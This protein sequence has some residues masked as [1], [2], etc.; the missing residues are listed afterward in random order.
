MSEPH[1][2]HPPTR[3]RVLPTVG[4]LARLGRW[5]FDHRL[6]A[7]GLWIVA[8]VGVFGAVGT[9]GPAYEDAFDVPNS[10][11]AEGFAVLEEH[12]AHLGAGGRSGTI[13][14]SAEQGVDDPHVMAAMQE[15]F[16]L[17]DSGFPDDAGVARHPGATVVSP[18]SAEGAGQIARDGPLSDQL[19]YAQVN[20]A[21]DIGLTEASQIGAAIADHAPV[22]DGLEVLPGGTALGEFAVPETE[23]IGLAFAV[24]ILIL[25]FGSVLAMG[26]PLAVAVA[27]VGAGVGLTALLS[28]LLTVPDY[29]TTVAIMIGLGVGIDYAL[30]I[31]VRYR[32]GLHEGLSPRAATTRAMDTAGRSVV[33]AGLTVVLSLLGILLIGLA[34]LSGLAI[35]ASVTVLVTMISAITLLP[36]LLGVAGPR[37]EV[38]R[39]RGV[40]MAAFVALALLGVGIGVPAL[41]AGGGVLA[42]VA[43]LTSFVLPA[44]RRAVPRRAVKPVSE[45]LAYRWSRTIQRR[46]RR[47]LVAGTLVLVVLASPILGLRLGFSDEGNAPDGTPTRVAY[48]LL[49]D[50]F[51][52]G[53]NGPFVVTA[54]LG[55]R[56]SLEAVDTLRAALAAAPGVAAVSEP[57]LDDPAAPTAA[58]MTLIPTTAPQDEATTDLVGDLRDRVI[59]TAVASAGLDVNIT[60]SAAAN[61]DYTEYLSGRIPL[62]FGAVLAVSFLLLMVVFRSVLV[63]LKAVVMNMLSLAAAYGV[64]VAVFQWGW[65]AD[66]FG[67][68]GAP[69]E[70]PLPLILFAIVFG[71]SMDYEVFLLSRVREE[72]AKTGDAARSVADGLAS[73]AR[74]I[75]AAAL[76]MIVVFGSFVLEADRGSKLFGFSLALAVFLDATLVRMLLVPAAM[77]L[78]G[79][80]NWWMP[81]WLDRLIP[82]VAVDRPVTEPAFELEPDADPI[83]TDEREP[84]GV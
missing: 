66:L 8:L 71:V 48:D 32:E 46:P 73:T 27:G 69:I 20:L 11:S 79:D 23:F 81:K 50:G 49:A 3:A 67:I 70:A 4:L 13:V 43:L 65:G 42:I 40:L 30:F 1:E 82:H 24:V 76:I 38:T 53:F 25:A 10:D 6:A 54:E 31:V 78:L 62:F 29:S 22:I 2:P 28:T 64:V 75:T 56:G 15:L 57:V 5:C 59:P 63:P 44:L 83:P 36:A 52:D 77:E 34:S 18:Y 26:L 39:W 19:A 12:F 17:V 74:V 41:T 45:T 84:V 55:T 47:W 68:S 58:V 37:I 7:V 61:V 60:G 14:F 16:T 35:G 33:F 80:K 21:A 9:V 72:Y 51:G